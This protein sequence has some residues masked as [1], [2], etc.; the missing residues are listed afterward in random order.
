MMKKTLILFSL[1]FLLV[2]GFAFATGSS[3]GGAT[4]AQA[5]VVKMRISGNNPDGTPA[6]EGYK[7]FSSKLKELTNGGI[8]L[9][10]FPSGQLGAEREVTEQVKAGALEFAHVS[11]GFLGAFVTSIDVF[12]VPY[13]FRSHDHYWN[14]MTG[15]I[16]EGMRGDVEKWGARLSI[17]V[18]GGS[19]S[20]Y[21][22]TRPITKPDDLKGLKIRVM[23]SPVMIKTMQFLGASPTTTAYAEVYN[24]LQTRVID[25]AENSPNSVASMK[26]NEVA[27]FF[28]LNEH[29]KIPDIVLMS[30]TAWNKLDNAGKE[31]VK[32][33]ET[34]A[35][36][37]I[38]TEWAR[39]ESLSLEAC[40]KT[41]TI[42][43][44]PDKTA[45]ITAVLPL[46]TD[47]EITAKFGDLVERIKNA[48]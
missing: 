17:W 7:Y 21:N 3:E 10:V 48:Q 5:Q 13:L 29:M 35:Q 16:G 37:W 47:P 28:S 23:G 42:N 19:R 32:T 27:K 44:I 43:T 36:G 46:H 30:N 20:F 15:P 6:T 18:D 22:N 33:A 8:A 31:A 4:Q 39:Q 41:M 25:G 9:D 11:A 24:A 14:V 2:A 1:V 34:D 40:G 26:H 45:F 12:N 38:K